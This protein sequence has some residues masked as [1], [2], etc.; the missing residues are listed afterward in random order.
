MFDKALLQK[1]ADAMNQHHFTLA[2]AESVTAGLLQV[3]FSSTENATT[4]FQGGVT[5]YNARQKYK[6][7]Y[8]NLL[9]AVSCNCVSPQIAN[10]M[11]LGVS[12]SFQTDWGIG[13]TGYA[14]PLPG[15]EM[16]PLYAY[17]AICYKNEILRSEQL[18]AN[19]GETLSVQLLYVKGI[20]EGL[21]Q[22]FAI[23]DQLS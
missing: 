6:Q 20:L 5:V 19:P 12:R 14:S 9:E 10:E 16:N 21:L 18:T 3:A 7:L 8:V 4:F 1:A 13:I 17:Y 23:H 22:T 2:V 11:A 15:H